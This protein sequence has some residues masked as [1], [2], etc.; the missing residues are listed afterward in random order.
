VIAAR[1]VVQ[2]V[3]VL[4]AD[5]TTGG[6]FT[7][8]TW[9]VALFLVVAIIGTGVVGVRGGRSLRS[10]LTQY[11][12]PI[13]VVQTTLLGFVGL[14]LAFGLS[15]G[16]GRFDERREA[17]VDEANAIGT[18]YLRS[19]ALPPDL[20]QR[21]ADLLRRYVVE[22]DQLSDLVPNT[23]RFDASRA[24]A[25][26]LTTELWTVALEALDR[27]PLGTAARLYT[28]SVNEVIDM[29]TERVD[30][31]LNRIPAPVLTVQ[32]FGSV[33]AV[34]VFGLFIGLLG[35]SH[36]TVL[37]ASVVIV[38]ILMVIVDLDRP[39]RGIID[40]PDG[41]LSA[42]RVAMQQPTP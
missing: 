8:P 14:L 7:I 16:V 10:R 12:E 41:A 29:E 26:A 9:G 40:T 39:V 17:I 38:L 33:A 19:S 22:R 3:Q 35:R 36:A 2:T 25:K 20:A 4:S 42:L 28:E 31:L 5:F 23:G 32:I 15:M 27:D 34:A 24:R 21:S 30:T 1:A 13:G 37:T 18:A 11:K 6:L